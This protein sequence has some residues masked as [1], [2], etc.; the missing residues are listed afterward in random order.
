M[1]GR[2]VSST[3]SKHESWSAD[4]P[5]E[6]VAEAAVWIARLHGP[7]RTP[8]LE[9]EC[10]SW[11]RRSALHRAAFEHSTATWD[12]IDSVTLA[13]VF[14]SPPR[15]E[16]FSMPR[17]R[18]IG[19]ACLITA[20][21]VVVGTSYWTAMRDASYATHVGEQRTLTLEDG[22]RMA[23]N[24]DT[25]LKVVRGEQVRLI[26]LAKGEVYF[27]VA[28]DPAHPFIVDAGNTQVRAV[29]TAFSVRREG[30][31]VFT[32]LFEGKIIVTEVGDCMTPAN[33]STEKP[34]VAGQSLLAH[35]Q[36]AP[37]ED[38]S[39]I[40][41]V[42]AWRRGEVVLDAMPLATAIA[43]INRYST[44][45]IKIDDE[46]IQQLP[47]SG[48][49]SIADA[50]EFAQAAAEVHHLVVVRENDSLWLTRPRS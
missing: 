4:L 23:I 10:A 50:E 21:C 27:E 44:T 16:L 12:A 39:A 42:N 11:L 32:T 49:F 43:E 13:A 22:S 14:R 2:S 1:D 30:D 38:V 31:K 20:L 48:I 37:S 5:A 9:Q 8:A 26:K 19:A 15:R 7:N 33:C 18:F 47:V 36:A 35:S 28:K 46:G 34:M 41:Q 24:T 40:Q 17:P 6:Y 45:H 3:E 29:G 25:E